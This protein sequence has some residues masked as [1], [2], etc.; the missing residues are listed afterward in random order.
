MY[1]KT[2]KTITEQK[3]IR[4]RHIHQ[5]LKTIHFEAKKLQVNKALSQTLFTNLRNLPAGHTLNQPEIGC[6]KCKLIPEYTDKSDCP[7]LNCIFNTMD[8]DWCVK[9]K[10]CFTPSRPDRLSVYFTFKELD[11]NAL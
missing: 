10:F 3:N 6:L 5:E 9:G 8:R 2:E 4:M 7:C 1:S 11:N